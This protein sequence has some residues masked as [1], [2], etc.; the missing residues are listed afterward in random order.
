MEHLQELYK[1]SPETVIA[2]MSME[3]TLTS[4]LSLYYYYETQR[5]KKRMRKSKKR[6]IWVRPYLTRMKLTEAW[7]ASCEACTMCVCVC[8]WRH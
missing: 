3:N 4:T 7:K 2:F 1:T 8:D 6:S 5:Q